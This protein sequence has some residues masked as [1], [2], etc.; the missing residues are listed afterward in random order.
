MTQF[1]YAV[2]AVVSSGIWSGVVATFVCYAEEPEGLRQSD[3]DTYAAFQTA[4]NEYNGPTSAAAQA[5]AQQAGGM[6][7]ATAAAPAVAPVQQQRV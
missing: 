5:A 2:V 3:P 6:A 1:G 4:W 7:P